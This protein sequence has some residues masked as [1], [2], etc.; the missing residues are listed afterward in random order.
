[1]IS[2]SR[3]L[4]SERL[5]RATT[6]LSTTEFKSL[7]A[8]FYRELRKERQVRY[9]RGVEQGVRER[10]PGGGRIGPLRTPKKKLFFILFH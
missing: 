5:I 7:R 4:G 8:G 1:M 9:E 6:G 10:R 2:V 3:A